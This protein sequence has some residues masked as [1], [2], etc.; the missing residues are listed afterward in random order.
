MIA[1]TILLMLLE[2]SL[3]LWLHPMQVDE[4]LVVVA[5]EADEELD[6]EVE[7]VEELDM[8]V[9]AVEVEPTTTHLHLLQQSMLRLPKQ[10]L[11][12]LHSQI[13]LLSP[14]TSLRDLSF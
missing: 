13:H 5:D 2:T 11:L 3:Q 7:A 1:Q 12:L 9:E 14:N 8:E 6:E 4:E 10:L